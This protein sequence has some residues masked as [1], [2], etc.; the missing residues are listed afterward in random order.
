M[1]TNIGVPLLKALFDHERKISGELCS[2][3]GDAIPIATGFRSSGPSYVIAASETD[4][5]TF[6]DAVAAHPDDHA[7][8]NLSA[9]LMTSGSGKTGPWS[10]ATY[11]G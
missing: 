2:I 1:F 9:V 11:R 10:N 3:G 6:M 7:H 5:G 4:Q 8:V